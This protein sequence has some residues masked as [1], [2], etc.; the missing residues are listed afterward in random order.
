MEQLRAQA[1]TSSPAQGAIIPLTAN[2]SHDPAQKCTTKH[3]TDLKLNTVNVPGRESSSDGRDNSRSGEIPTGRALSPGKIQQPKP[4]KPYESRH[5]RESDF[6][7]PL[8]ND[9][10]SERDSDDYWSPT[11][12]PGG[13][14]I[15]SDS[16]SQCSTNS[17]NCVSSVC[18]CEF[19]GATRSGQR[20]KLPCDGGCNDSSSECSE[21]SSYCGEKC[22]DGS[23]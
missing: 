6:S 11:T 5:L 18:R 12:S 4:Q 23:E 14:T 22:N 7:A 21:S 9:G 20:V 2:V 15:F 17:L 16:D 3:T 10:D 13:S 8:T 19:Y 1:L